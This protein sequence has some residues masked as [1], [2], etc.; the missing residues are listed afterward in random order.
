MANE[1]LS[2]SPTECSQNTFDEEEILKLPIE[3]LKNILKFV[4]EPSLKKA[5]LVCHRFYVVICELERD[6]N[7]LQLS[8][9][10]VMT[11]NFVLPFKILA[12]RI[13]SDLR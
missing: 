12:I 4:D 7:P 6:K 3:V 5:I 1:L 10:E 8:Y 11:V 13:L 2:V 9:S